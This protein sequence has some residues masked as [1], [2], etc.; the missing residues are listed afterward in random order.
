MITA[1]RLVNSIT[2]HSYICAS[3]WRKLLR[4]LGSSRRGSAETNLMSIHENTG[5][6]PGLAQW[7]KLQTQLRSG[8][9]VTVV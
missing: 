2:S 9:A 1:I 5:L 3:L 4:S 7:C 8:V 6:I